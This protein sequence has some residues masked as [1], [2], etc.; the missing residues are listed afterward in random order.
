MP[1]VDLTG[2]CAKLQ[3][4]IWNEKMEHGVR[5]DCKKLRD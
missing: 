3:A 2:S 4:H 1:I 5:A